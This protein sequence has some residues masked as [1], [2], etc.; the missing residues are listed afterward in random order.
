MA[1]D[2][3]FAGLAPAGL[4]P[5][6]RGQQA[7]PLLSAV[8]P[9]MLPYMKE[10]KLKRML[11][12]DPAKKADELD[13][14]KAALMAELEG[15]LRQ[16]GNPGGAG[17]CSAGSSLPLE[18]CESTLYGVVCCIKV[19]WLTTDR[20]CQAAAWSHSLQQAVGGACWLQAVLVSS[21]FN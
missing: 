14:T 18:D 19:G 20:A 9:L 11:L 2:S 16:I 3:A 6:V 5:Q 21:L 13:S 12:E 15:A 4:H 7:G 1:A 10:K 17:G 8:G